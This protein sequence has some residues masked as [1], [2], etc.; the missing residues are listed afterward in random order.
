MRTCS[1]ESLLKPVLLLHLGIS[2]NYTMHVQMMLKEFEK[3]HLLLSVF[4][5]LYTK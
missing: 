1:K 5:Y 2:L 4:L 3:R